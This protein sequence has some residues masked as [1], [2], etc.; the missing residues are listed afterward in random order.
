M[1]GTFAGVD[2]PAR[3]AFFVSFFFL[4][5]VLKRIERA[6]RFEDRGVVRASASARLA[7]LVA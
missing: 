1:T 7:L 5:L 6:K 4:A 2:A 3:T